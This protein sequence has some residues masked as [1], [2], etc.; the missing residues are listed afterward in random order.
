MRMHRF[1][2]W[3]VLGISVGVCVD[4]GASLL[5]PGSGGT[6]PIS[7]VRVTPSMPSASSDVS[8]TVSGWKP[9]S[10]YAIYDTDLRI[11]G[12]VIRLDLDWHASGIGLQVVMQYEHTESL[13]TLDPGIYTVYVT[14]QGAMSG[15]ATA[16][17]IVSGAP[18]DSQPGSNDPVGGLDLSE[19]LADHSISEPNLPGFEIK[20]VPWSDVGSIKEGVSQLRIDPVCPTPSDAVSVT[21]SGWKPSSDLDVERAT[22]RTGGSEIWLDLYWHTRPLMPLA[23]GSGICS[24]CSESA[25]PVTIIQYDITSYNGVPFTHTE[26]LGTFSSGT[27]VLHV[28]NHSPMSGS[29][30]TSFAVSPSTG[31]GLMKPLDWPVLQGI[32]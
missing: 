19:W 15:C 28:T 10:N 16:T 23:G 2:F 6:A 26:Q 25:Q 17:F 31:S 4:S 7:E 24:L 27:Y 30:S 18:N 29:A 12:F 1:L 9:A 21:V 8:V 14:N 3:I 20:H 13:G 32:H 22:V 5:S 11:E